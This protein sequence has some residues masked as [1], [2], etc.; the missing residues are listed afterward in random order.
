MKRPN[1]AYPEV[2]KERLPIPIHDDDLTNLSTDGAYLKTAAYAKEGDVWFD[3]DM[4]GDPSLSDGDLSSK[5]G[6]GSKY[7]HFSTLEFTEPHASRGHNSLRRISLHRYRLN[8][9]WAARAG[10]KHADNAIGA[11][12]LAFER[13]DPSTALAD[14][15]TMHIGHVHSSGKD[16]ANNFKALSIGNVDITQIDIAYFPGSGYIAGMTF[17]DQVNEQRTER[18][19]WRQWEGKEPEGLIHVLNAPPDRGDGTVWKF[20]GLTGTWI[21]T[22]GHG[23]V[24]ARVSGVWK[25]AG[26]E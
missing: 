21:D 12:G 10:L 26:E 7:E 4:V 8:L 9:S 15:C 11:I 3:Y 23:H 6:I 13:D 19:R 25:K 1:Y 2:L 22:M 17:Y 14:G 5:F 24:L 16:D 18:L 20:A